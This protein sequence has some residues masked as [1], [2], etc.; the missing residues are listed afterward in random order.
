[1]AGNKR[2]DRFH[3]AQNSNTYGYDQAFI[4]IQA[5]RKRSHWIW[6]IFPQLENLGKSPSAKLYG[7][8]DFNEAC[9]YLKDP[10]LFKRYFELI[11]LI[12]EK[13]K[14]IPLSDLM[15]GFPDDRKFISS[16]TLFQAAS[17]YLNSKETGYQNKY[18]PLY[19]M[20]NRVFKQIS[21][22]GYSPCQ[23]T[24]LLVKHQ[25]NSPI[26]GETTEKTN[27]PPQMT[28]FSPKR[29]KANTDHPILKELTQYINKRK[30]EWSYHYNFLGIVAFV[31]FIQDLILGTDHF[32][33]KTR[34]VKL[35]AAS[36]LQKI[37]D[38][39]CHEQCNLNPS[40]RKALSDGRLGKIINKHGGLAKILTEAPDKL[41]KT[42][43]DQ[44]MNSNLFS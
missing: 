7:I 43:R 23:Q 3:N 4:E 14:S 27:P 6:Y 37:L 21:R 9:D 11:K 15:S 13:L 40:E 24:E 36:K 26:K 28:I 31:Y 2:L 33:R 10:V 34:Q 19:E 42:D 29:S 44:E 30:N 38:P 41:A 32:N 1:M 5:G 25:L 18:H 35:T 39:K 8:K 16:L 12:E 20:C 17:Y 22:Q